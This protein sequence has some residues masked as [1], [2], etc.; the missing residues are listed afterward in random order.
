[1]GFVMA[2]INPAYKN[3]V[4]Y[5]L[6]H[7]L[8]G[9]KVINE[10][11]GWNSDDKE[12]S[13]HKKYR[14]VFTKFSNNLKFIEDGADYINQV[15]DNY[16][17][18]AEIWLKREIRH[19]YSDI[20]QLD[21]NGVLDLS[22]WSTENF[23]VKVKF[24]S[25]G[26]ETEIKARESEKVEIERT[27]SL[28]GDSL[29]I[30]PT[31]NVELEGRKIFLQSVLEG[32]TDTPVITEVPGRNGRYHTRSTTFPLKVVSKSDELI[33][34]SFVAK[35][36]TP[37]ASNIFY[38][39]NDREKKI[40]ISLKGSFIIHPVKLH[41]LRSDLFIKL[42]L[43]VYEDGSNY[44]HKKDILLFEDSNPR[45]GVD[46]KGTFDKTLELT[47]QKGESLCLRL[48]TGGI[49]GSRYW[50]YGDFI[51]EY[52]KIDTEVTIEENSFFEKSSTKVVLAH[53]LGERLL[54]IITGRKGVFYSEYLGRKEIG[55]DEDGEGALKG[56]SCGHWIR[57]FDEYPKTG[58]NKYKPFTT[59]LKDYFDDLISTENVG[60]GIEKIGFREILVVRPLEDF[61]INHV[62]IKLPYQISNVKR[63]IAKKYF[64]SSIT[65]GCEKGWENEEA[66]G[67][68]EYNT[69][70]LFITP[71]IRVKNEFKRITKYIYATYAG[72]FIRRKQKTEYPNLDHRNDTSIF[73]FALKRYY[74]SFKLRKWQ[75]DLET[76]PTGVY[77]PE[78]AFN[79]R[80]TPVNLLLKHKWFIAASLDKYLKDYV[81]FGNS[82]GNSSLKTK[83]KNKKEYAENQDVISS[84]FEQPRFIPEEIEFEHEFTSEVKEQ[85]EGTT[86]I[87]GK[88]V[89]NIYGLIEF[90]NEKGE[91]E[92]GRFENLK[93]NGKGKWR[94]LKAI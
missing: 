8:H 27:T 59:S 51:H 22:E 20:W 94:L 68:D 19:P 6:S 77:S 35:F 79:F 44:K 61:Y 75:D 36:H 92:R 50:G 73:P 23:D 16:G 39:H 18:N 54:R 87:D 42:L 37:D 30:L 80:Y 12:Y 48:F 29:P 86:V 32:N 40:K 78:T 7:V 21:Y 89:S 64:Y 72:E 53:E 56:Y 41:R 49:V 31:H 70:S 57:G 1:M 65:V 46:R 58:S 67:L 93:P 60:I 28:N 24:N 62:T 76:K 83:F 2:D 90:I 45:S 4:R 11:E 81:R 52:K 63:K 43:S 47:L 55:Y 26:L 5:T 3:R 71:I 9:S 34:D 33:Q 38:G 14:G 66:M 10:P 91:K 88:E 82:K 17:I 25:S 13:R 74:N 84:D 15:K 69:Q 85:L